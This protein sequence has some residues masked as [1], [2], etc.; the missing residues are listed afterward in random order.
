MTKKQQSIL[1]MIKW[2][3]DIEF[4]ESV[5]NVAWNQI[6]AQFDYEYCPWE[7]L[8]HDKLTS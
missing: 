8:C 5:R 2:E 7:D 6:Q 1:R 3:E 4:L